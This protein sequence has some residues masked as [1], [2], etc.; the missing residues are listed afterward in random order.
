VFTFLSRHNS[1]F[2]VFLTNEKDPPRHPDLLYCT[3]HPFN[4]E[5]RL[6]RLTETFL[7]PNELHYTRCH[8][9]V[10]D[11]DPE[12]WEL[13]VEG[14]GI[15]NPTTFTLNDLKTKFKKYEIVTGLQ[16]AGNRR[17]DMH[18]EGTDIFIGPH[19]VSGAISCSKWGGVRLRDVLKYCGLD[20]DAMALGELYRDDCTHV[21]FEGYVLFVCCLRCD[22]KC[23]RH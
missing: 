2:S 4:G 8:L 23:F 5:P 22:H 14:N 13:E 3:T 7:T 18:G 19:W 17:E 11:I 1:V 10:P 6:S 16:C 12:D 15:T 9:P 21:Q 20:V